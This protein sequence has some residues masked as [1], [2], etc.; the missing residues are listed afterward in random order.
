MNVQRLRDGRRALGGLP[1]YDRKKPWRTFTNEAMIRRSAKIYSG[2]KHDYEI[3]EDVV[4]VE[5]VLYII[6]HFEYESMQQ[7][8]C[9]TDLAQ[10]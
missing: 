7:D 6:K 10:Q 8:C 5:E 3:D 1:K 2:K 4:R 9:H